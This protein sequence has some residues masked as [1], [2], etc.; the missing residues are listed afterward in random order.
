MF[1]ILKFSYKKSKILTKIRKAIE[2]RKFDA[3]SILEQSMKNA[4]SGNTM[5][6]KELYTEELLTLLSNDQFTT[7]LLEEHNL[8]FNDLRDIISTLEQNGAG[9]IVKGHYVAISSIAF[10]D[11]LKVLCNYWNNG[12][13]EIDGKSKQESNEIMAYQML[14]SF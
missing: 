9:Q 7:N 2:S 12:G 13:F 14:Q 4:V 3:K 8:K 10:V 5:S 6:K 1:K 11:T